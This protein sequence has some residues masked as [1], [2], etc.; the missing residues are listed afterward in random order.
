MYIAH[1]KLTQY[2]II[3]TVHNTEKK[4]TSDHQLKISCLDKLYSMKNKPQ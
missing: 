4:I 1:T 2:T 3:H